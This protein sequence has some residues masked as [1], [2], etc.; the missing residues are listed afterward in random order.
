MNFG[1]IFRQIVSALF[2]VAMLLCNAVSHAEIKNYEGHGEHY[3]VDDETTDFAKKQAELEAWRN[4]LDKICV[5]VKGQS[6]MID[7]ELEEDEII[8]I[9]TGILRVIDT[10][11]AIAVEDDA[12]VVTAFVTAIIDTDELASLLDNAIKNR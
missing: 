8:T 1:K 4:I 6:I 7:N 11:H 12:L 2:I 3:I 9:A 5:Y 10:K